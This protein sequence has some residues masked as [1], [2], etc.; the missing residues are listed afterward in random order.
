MNSVSKADIDATLGRHFELA[1]YR[2]E[3]KVT[4]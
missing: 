2:T 1:Y 4:R 3:A